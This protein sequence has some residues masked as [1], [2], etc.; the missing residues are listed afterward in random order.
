[1]TRLRAQSHIL[2]PLAMLPTGRQRSFRRMS[3]IVTFAEYG[4]VARSKAKSCS[5]PNAPS[6]WR[7]GI[8]APEDSDAFG[9]AVGHPR[10]GPDRQ[11]DE[12]I[13]QNA[14]TTSCGAGAF[15][16]A[17]ATATTSGALPASG[18]LPPA[19][20]SP[21]GTAQPARL[22][23]HETVQQEA[24]SPGLVRRRSQP[25]R[26][27]DGLRSLARRRGTERPEELCLARERR[28]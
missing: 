28:R 7:Q 19:T 3:A 22:P 13:A 23:V 21:T 2:G 9:G 4:R 14:L 6:C 17:A 1:M 15:F 26:G 10:H 27:L 20:K 11:V 5:R 16:L 24:N 8:E 12:P 18:R 25:S